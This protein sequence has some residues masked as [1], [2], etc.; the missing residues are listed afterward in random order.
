[1][2]WASVP[3]AAIDEDRHAKT[4][5]HDVGLAAERGKRPSVSK[6]PQTPVVKFPAERHLRKG[7]AARLCTHAVMDLWAGREREGSNGR[8]AFN[9]D[10][11]PLPRREMARSGSRILWR[12]A[13]F[14]DSWDWLPRLVGL[15]RLT[16]TPAFDLLS[17]ESLVFGSPPACSTEL[18]VRRS[19]RRGSRPCSL[20]LLKVGP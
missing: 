9:L 11:E 15:S 13:A 4:R 8:H 16:G 3:E 19:L 18:V 1:M 12:R 6:V 2:S 20:G 14:R 5:E 10:F 17:T 7:V